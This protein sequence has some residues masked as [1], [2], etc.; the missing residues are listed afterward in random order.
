[1]PCGD[2]DGLGGVEGPLAD[3]VFEEAALDVL[4][5]DEG[6]LHLVP[7][8]VAHR[9][10]SGVEDADDGRVGHAG[11][12]L[13]L[14]AEA[15]AEGG[16]GGERRLHQLDRDAA[17]EPG[18]GADVHVGHA[19]PT[20]QLADLVPVGEEV[21]ALSHTFSHALLSR[22]DPLSRSHGRSQCTGR[23][24]PGSGADATPE[25]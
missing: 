4:H 22:R 9:L 5:D 17:A 13:G 20:D 24:A 21:N 12:G 2:A 6:H 25:G 18:V 14:L 7:L 8:R 15:G 16:I 3:D 19:A 10:F 23:A 11:G 1:M